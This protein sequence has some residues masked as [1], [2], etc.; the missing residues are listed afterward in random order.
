LLYVDSTHGRE[1]TKE[2]AAAWQRALAPDALVVLDDF[3][4][5]DFPG[6]REAVREL[7]L[8]GQQ[9]GTLFVHELHLAGRGA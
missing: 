6:V 5:P 7:G 1:E 9:R 8:S 3:N 4:H 2:R